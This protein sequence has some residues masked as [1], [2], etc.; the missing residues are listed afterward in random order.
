MIETVT[1]TNHAANHSTVGQQ[2]AVN[3][4]KSTFHQYTTYNVNPSDP[5]ERKVDVAIQ[6]LNGGL[7]RL[8]EELL[9]GVVRAGHTDG[10]TAYYY[11]LSVL[12]DRTF[13]EYTP[14]VER[15]F[16]TACDLGAGL[17]ATPWTAGL[18]V[19]EDLVAVALRQGAGHQEQ[20][21]SHAVLRSLEAL[22][23]ERRLEITRN[24]DRLV[25][26]MLQAGLDEA[27]A[28][29]VRSAR[30]D[31]G[32]VDRAW[33][34][35][36]A[37][38]AEPRLAE[39]EPLKSAGFFWLLLACATAL[40]G[41]LALVPLMSQWEA[42]LA[43]L[44]LGAGV[45]LMR[46]PVREREARAIRL[47]RLDRDHGVPAETAPTG[48]PGHWVPTA[49]VTEMHRRVE[50]SFRREHLH[51]KGKWLEETH[52]IREELKRRFVTLYGNAQRTPAQ[53]D[54]L[55]RWHTERIAR[56]WL[57]RTLYDYRNELAP[58][59]PI[60]VIIG[61]G[62]VVASLIVMQP[63]GAQASL[64][65]AVAVACCYRWWCGP[66]ATAVDRAAA[67]THAQQL[68]ALEQQAYLDWKAVLADRPTDAEMGRWLDLDRA[69]LRAVALSRCGLVGRDLVAHVVITEGAAGA[70]KARVR[71]APVRYSAYRILIFLLTRHGMR[72]VEVRL[73]FLDGSSHDEQRKAFQYTSLA[74][75][76]VV[77]KGVRLSADLRTAPSADDLAGFE[78]EN[79]TRREFTLSLLDGH[80][81]T[82]VVENF[83][84]MR[85]TESE[86]ESELLSIALRA[87]GVEGALHILETVAAEGPQW[88]AREEE[89][90]RRRYEDWRRDHHDG[91]L[92][93]LAAN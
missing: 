85:A 66:R 89:R 55:I 14:A 29:L 2:N 87:S 19:V 57:D 65:F 77:E 28:A 74:S 84:G 61:A 8:A 73:D 32:R 25:D 10:R 86:S 23:E 42:W 30:F 44:L 67:V 4:G 68:H 56:R 79:L 54:W 71:R 64:W 51:S 76:R 49:F 24:L 15:D 37:D 70:D 46:N 92:S 38:P 27:N 47:R 41:L 16:R 20:A 78:E 75:T 43:L 31:N 83:R 50:L 7:P 72:E 33:K 13:P 69:H 26:G 91:G 93:G 21:A 18:S 17:P 52:G 40:A 39:P 34:F 1:N 60:K 5:P 90:R 82:A 3:Y 59:N 53:Y 11:A 63:G 62:L 48:S 88:L 80:P 12:G 45:L 36:E 9:A 22:P 6:Y 81:I 35:F 58:T